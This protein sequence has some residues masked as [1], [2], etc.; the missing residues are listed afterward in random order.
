LP[1][2]YLTGEWWMDCY[3]EIDD[4]ANSHL[5]EAEPTE[6]GQE[7]WAEERLSGHPRLPRPC[8]APS[9]DSMDARMMFPCRL[10]ACTFRR[11]QL[12]LPPVTE[13]STLLTSAL[14]PVQLAHCICGE[15]VA[16]QGFL[17]LSRPWQNVGQ[18]GSGQIGNFLSTAIC[19]RLVAASDETDLETRLRPVNRNQAYGILERSRMGQPPW[20]SLAFSGSQ[21]RSSIGA[22]DPANR[23]NNLGAFA[24]S[25]TI[26]L[27]GKTPLLVTGTR[28]VD[29]FASTRSH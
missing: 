26:E 9:L 3:S 21:G 8:L 23:Q 10:H 20:A 17:P 19:N 16:D 1:Q 5:R 29:I 18:R 7:R 6:L 24:L 14:P 27:G 4:V 13:R 2:G 22:S 11:R 15:A 25:S 28:C 12:F